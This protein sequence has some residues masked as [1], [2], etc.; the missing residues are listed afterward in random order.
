[1]EYL[2]SQHSFHSIY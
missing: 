2:I 1:M